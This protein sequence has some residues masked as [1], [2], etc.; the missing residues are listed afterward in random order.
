MGEPQEPSV[1]F[2]GE[3]KAEDAGA[4]EGDG[5]LGLRTIR[6]YISHFKAWHFAQNHPSETWKYVGLAIEKRKRDDKES[7][8]IV[9][10]VLVPHKRLKHETSRHYYTQIE[11]VANASPSPP[12]EPMTT[13]CTPPAMTLEL[14]WPS[15]L[16]VF[17]LKRKSGAA[18]LHHL[19]FSALQIYVH[20]HEEDV[21]S[22]AKANP[23][24]NPS[25]RELSS[26]RSFALAEIL[27]AVHDGDIP[28]LEE[29]HCRGIS[30]NIGNRQGIFPLGL[31]ASEALISLEVCKALLEMGASPNFDP[32][33]KNDGD[34]PSVLHI[35]AT[36]PNDEL[37]KLLL[38]NGANLHNL[39]MPG[40][41]WRGRLSS[42]RSLSPLNIAIGLGRWGLVE[43]L[44]SNGAPV[45]GNELLQAVM[46]AY[47]KSR[48]E[49]PNS[50]MQSLVQHGVDLRLKNNCGENALHIC[51][52]SRKLNMAKCLLELGSQM[53]AYAR[54]LMHPCISLNELEALERCS[55]AWDNGDVGRLHALLESNSISAA[56]ALEVG[57]QQ[58][59]RSQRSHDPSSF[60]FGEARHLSEFPRTAK[61]IQSTFPEA[62][63]SSLI[64]GI[65]WV[66]N[67][68]PLITKQ[69]CQEF[70]QLL[71]PALSNRSRALTIDSN[72]KYALLSAINLAAT[73][74][75]CM[76][77]ELILGTLFSTP[78]IVV[79]PWYNPFVP[80]YTPEIERNLYSPV[81]VEEFFNAQPSWWSSWK[82]NIRYYCAHMLFHRQYRP[83]TAAGLTSVA[84]GSILEVKQLMSLG[85]DPRRRYA[86]SLTAL[87]SAVYQGQKDMV[88]FLLEEGVSVI[89]CPPWKELTPTPHPECPKAIRAEPGNKDRRT[90][91]QYAVQSGDVEM[92]DLLLKHKA[93]VNEPPARYAGATAL[94]L[95]AI[96]GSIG[97]TKKL[98]DLGADVNAARAP[99]R[100]RTALE[101]AAEHGRLDTVA[102]LLELGCRIDG[103]GRDQYIRA[104]KLAR[105][106][107]H[108]AL[109]SLLESRG[110]W[111]REDERILEAC[112][113]D[114]EEYEYLHERCIGPCCSIFTSVY[115]SPDEPRCWEAQSVVSDGDLDLHDEAYTTHEDQYIQESPQE[116]T[117]VEDGEDQ[118]YDTYSPVYSEVQSN[119][120]GHTGGVSVNDS[121][122]VDPMSSWGDWAFDDDGNFVG[123]L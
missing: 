13:V 110:T 40:I 91:F 122:T 116:C 103:K 54:K 73:H 47:N 31:A 117:D 115:E 63:C 25:P 43:L 60:Y 120:E 99:Y 45:R 111:T 78:M 64:L 119:V 42:S 37:P 106:N 6:E 112:K 33:T 14:E 107:D 29:L 102:L 93:D 75:E 62:Y 3:R 21:A 100:G 19:D 32:S 36:V 76:P 30:F 56:R 57:A 5:S 105:D 95:S 8:V 39:L 109:A 17:R 18:V 58:L 108:L 121:G 69:K 23:V 11:K 70:E 4:N 97:I 52:R 41:Y 90:A 84:G 59:F 46:Q 114:E 55:D 87:Q 81:H 74:G 77:M 101:G 96:R 50:V 68:C 86:W 38:E 89:S 118:V 7:T 80:I 35:A 34:L 113:I 66:L 82:D 92:I 49:L 16:P 61:F 51:I 48:P 123:S 67:G 1:V 15:T 26:S 83:N 2:M 72:E 44:L 79:N 53:D 20:H 104:V 12:P 88:L 65:V 71:R 28:R 24:S 22:Q 94:Q 10:G 9:D 98:I 85:F 27:L